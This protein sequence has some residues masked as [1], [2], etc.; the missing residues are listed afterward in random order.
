[1]RE[2]LIPVHTLIMMVEVSCGVSVCK[3]YKACPNTH[4][5]KWLCQCDPSPST[6]RATELTP[7]SSRYRKHAF[8]DNRY[9]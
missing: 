3:E 2:E 5:A 1:M 6:V 8:N 9:R 4:F 7:E